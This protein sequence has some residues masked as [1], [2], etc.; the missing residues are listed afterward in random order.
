MTARAQVEDVAWPCSTVTLW[1]GAQSGSGKL[2]T[3]RARGLGARSS[4]RRAGALG[5]EE[6][7]DGC[8]VAL[9]FADAA[10][11]GSQGYFSAEVES[12]FGSCG[13]E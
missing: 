7:C 4:S 11:T 10:D 13:E 12:R 8:A 2:R 3:R 5:G 9:A 1:E 6:G